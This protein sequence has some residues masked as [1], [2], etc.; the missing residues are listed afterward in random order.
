VIGAVTT[1]TMAARPAHSYLTRSER[2]GIPR[3]PN[4]A[5][6]GAATET[7]SNIRSARSRT[8]GRALT[9]GP[10][11]TYPSIWR[12]ANPDVGLAAPTDG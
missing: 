8:I 9:A 1:V 10:S 4:D 11:N 12:D 2:S 7:P 6:S 3:R 5:G